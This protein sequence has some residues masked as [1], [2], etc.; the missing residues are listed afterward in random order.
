MSAP[1]VTQT[2]KPKVGQRIIRALFYSMPLG[3]LMFMLVLYIVRSI[4]GIAG[5]TVLPDIPLAIG[6]FVMGFA[7]PLGI[8]FSKYLSDTGK[9]KFGSRIIRALFYSM[10]LGYLAFLIFYMLSTAI[11]GVAGTPVVP[12]TYIGIGGFVM[13]FSLPIAIEISKDMES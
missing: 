12:S 9:Y 5:S 13:G 2:K 7:L 1:M 10:P 4:N 6:G 11:N 8:E 3:Y